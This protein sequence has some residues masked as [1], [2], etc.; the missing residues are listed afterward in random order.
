MYII[1]II[2]RKDTLE[3]Q[4]LPIYLSPP[5]L[6]KTL[7]LQ[8]KKVVDSVKIKGNVPAI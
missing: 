6:C 3:V 2:F 5:D 4:W 1:T 8:K 7:S